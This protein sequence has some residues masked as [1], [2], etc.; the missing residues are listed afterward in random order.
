VHERLGGTVLKPEPRSLRITGTVVEWEE[1]T[2]MAFPESGEYPF[3][4]GLACLAV[5]R[6]ADSGAYWEPNVWVR[7]EV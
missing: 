5:D 7:H 6:E 3:P 1:W 4:G 2:G